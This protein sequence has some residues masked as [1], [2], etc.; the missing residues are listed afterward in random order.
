MSAPPPPNPESGRP[1]PVLDVRNLVTRFHTDRGV[2]HAVEDVSFRVDAGETLAIVGES[3]SGKSVTAMSLMG[4]VRRPGRVES[5]Q[6]LYHGRDLT[7]LDEAAMR[8]VRGAGIGMV[9]QDPMS[10]L[11]PVMRI[12][13]QLVEGM[14]A[15]G[16]FT[17]AQATA[18][19]RDLMAMVGIPDPDARLA[20]Y[21]H[22]FSGGMRQRVVIA[23]AIANEPDVLIADEP[24]TALD[25]TVQAQVLDLLASLNRELGTAIVLI[26]HNLGV[27]ARICDRAAVMYGGR[28]V[29][30]GPVDALFAEP[31]H[32]YTRDLLAATPRLRARRDIPLVPIPGRPPDLLLPSPGCA[33]A[34]RCAHADDICAT[35]R[36]PRSSGQ[37]RTWDCWRSTGGRLVPRDGV[38][39][40]GDGGHAPAAERHPV[41]A[42]T[43]GDGDSHGGEVLLS[44]AG[45]GK[46]FP[47]R[48][49]RSPA[50][51]ALDGIDLRLRRGETVGLVGESGCGK[52]TL[53]KV[54]LGIERPTA[55]TLRY[56]DRDESRAG[57]AELRT[58]RRKVQIVFQD[59]YSSLNP[60]MTVGQALAEPLRL[61]HRAD[62]SGLDAAV[63]ELLDLVGLDPSVA[64]RYPHEFS[65]G[66]RQRVVIA[67]ALAVGPELIVCDEA[68]SA[69]DVSLQAQV[70]NL[71]ADLQR[72]LGLTYLFIGHD[73]ATVRHLS[74]RIAVM[75]LGQIVEEG[76]AEQVTARP[77]HPYTV[78][79]LSAVPEPDPAVERSR[80]RIV[81][82]GDVSAP[83]APPPGCR[84]HTRCPIGPAVHPERT[85]CR[86]QRPAL[87]LTAAGHAAA[88]HFAG[89]LTAG[90]PVPLPIPAL[91]KEHL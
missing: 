10:S 38:D 44:L 88:C 20:D 87:S 4:M 79:L 82:T 63:A 45:V 52:S 25:V 30:Q 76:P 16:K 15:H 6:V 85:V 56:A 62:A 5:G 8:Q 73:L 32:P 75:Y 28:I 39:G 46:T 42:R 54:V 41:P 21:P 66:Q 22:A 49:R 55:G 60:R 33:F 2:V 61:H 65:G 37:D 1:A 17:G 43:D 74:D 78:S 67:R 24:T 40:D 34:D 57:R 91:S 23:M 84:F 51:G 64:E 35:Q 53:G 58:L 26:T 86:E 9:F 90:G 89:E 77:Q 11:N 71:L 47:G 7:S 18:R 68:V 14:L 70:V 59:P 36:P 12:R 31:R 48:T 27:V 13:D 19:A 3:G 83:T 29:E 81:L 50:V 72:R 80:E 69:L